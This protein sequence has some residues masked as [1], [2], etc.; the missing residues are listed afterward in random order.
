MFSWH[1]ESAPLWSGRQRSWTAASL[2]RPVLLGLVCFFLNAGLVPESSIA[3]QTLLPGSSIEAGSAPQ[4]APDTARVLQTLGSLRKMLKDDPKAA[5]APPAG[6]P[7]ANNSAPGSSGGLVP[8]DS[9]NQLRDAESLHRKLELL[10]EMMH[11]RDANQSVLGQLQGHSGAHPD[12][13]PNPQPAAPNEV[14]PPSHAGDPHSTGDHHGSAGHGATL[15][16]AAEAPGVDAITTD[17]VD[18]L[19]LGHSLFATGNHS[20]ALKTWQGLESTVV[21]P[22]ERQWMDYFVASSLRITGDREAAEA[23]Y[24]DLVN[25]KQSGYPVEAAETWLRWIEKR[26]RTE[27]DRLRILSALDALEQELQK[28]GN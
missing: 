9:G 16:P 2:F 13:H 23:A 28:N 5:P 3:A 22:H 25:S 27:E 15:D 6:S 4:P 10:R 17:P 24:R 26:K 8:A 20:L 14:L 11:Q 19:A 21:E 7:G 18:A 1:G 12:P